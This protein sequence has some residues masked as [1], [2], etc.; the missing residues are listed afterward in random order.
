MREQGWFGSDRE[1]RRQR[2]KIR[3]EM[4]RQKTR[5][6][7][8]EWDRIGRILELD[9]DWWSEETVFDMFDEG[10]VE[11][12]DEE[13][14]E[15]DED[16]AVPY[17]PTHESDAIL[18]FSL[19]SL[20]RLLDSLIRNAKPAIRP[21]SRRAAPANGLYYLSRFACVWCDA[22]WLE[23]VV[24]GAVDKI[25]ETVHVRFPLRMHVVSLLNVL[26]VFRAVLRTYRT[27]RSGFSILPCS[28]IF[29]GA[30]RT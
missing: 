25:E 30:T 2:A 21:M 14:E 6:R 23:E 8:E 16:E 13:D 10:A 19:E 29:S 24:V 3:M 26:S 18:V 17:T 9:E 28:S 15:E 1:R 22:S 7:K 4:I 20:P 27:L 11:D 12:S 5:R